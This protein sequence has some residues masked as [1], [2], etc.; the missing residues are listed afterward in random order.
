LVTSQIYGAED[1]LV[2][3]LWLEEDVDVENK[4]S[5]DRLSVSQLVV[6]DRVSVLVSEA[7]VELSRYDES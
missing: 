1:V 6:R 5:E 4:F 3:M 7:V 2:E